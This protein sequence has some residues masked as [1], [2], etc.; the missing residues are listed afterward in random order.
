MRWG[1]IW[2]FLAAW[3]ACGMAAPTLWAIGHRAPRKPRNLEEKQRREGEAFLEGLLLTGRITFIPHSSSMIS[4]LKRS[5]TILGVSCRDA[6][7]VIQ[8]VN[9]RD[10]G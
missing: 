4:E 3:L 10:P 8:N 9:K 2:N 1:I 5:S 7:T 6:G